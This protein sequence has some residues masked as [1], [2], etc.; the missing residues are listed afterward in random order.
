MSE[1]QNRQE[2]P[3]DALPARNKFAGCSARNRR[4]SSSFAP[5]ILEFGADLRHRRF[6]RENK[7][8]PSPII[9]GLR[10]ILNLHT[11]RHFC[12]AERFLLYLACR[13]DRSCCS[14]GACGADW[15]CCSGASGLT[16]DSLGSCRAWGSERTARP[17][18]GRE[19]GKGHLLFNLERHEA[20]PRH[21]AR[22][23]FTAVLSFAS[24]LCIM[25]GFCVYSYYFCSMFFW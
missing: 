25:R 13:T 18:L 14:D 9:A 7:I 12:C 20:R 5:I 2:T 16:W 24:P 8:A 19:D 11:L 15:T 6:W 1:T 10:A 17:R 3:H 21:P 22:Y 23:G 4:F